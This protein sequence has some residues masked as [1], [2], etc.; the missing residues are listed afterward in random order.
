M[1][2]KEKIKKLYQKEH[3]E[4]ALSYKQIQEKYN[5]PRGT[6]QY[7]VNKMNLKYDGRKFRYVD[8][9]FDDID[10]Y[11]KAYILGFLYADGCITSDGRISILL[12]EKDIEIL[13]FIKSEICPDVEI[14][15][16]NYQNIKR[17]SQIK[18]RFMSKQIYSKLIE[19][20]FVVDK[21]GNDSNIFGFIPEEFKF[22][23]IRGYCDGDGNIRCQYRKGKNNKF[24]WT[25]SFSFSNGSKQ[26]LEDIQKYLLKFNIGNGKLIS[27]KNKNVFYTLSYHRKI[28]TL[29]FCKL[30]YSNLN[31]F[32][33]QRKKELALKTIEVCSNTE[34]NK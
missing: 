31:K 33:L 22:D 15:H 17:D 14:K 3:V 24:Y 23:F 5:I 19:Y 1:E 11:K 12:N 8:D 2:M 25:N 30:V 16:S 10:N 20:G 29:N 7:Y 26:I 27:Y 4:N 6:W 21:T 28:D 13:K 9:Y 34:V 18:L 32:S